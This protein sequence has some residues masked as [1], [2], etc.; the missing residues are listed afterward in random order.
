[1]VNTERY[2]NRL[3][4]L[5]WDDRLAE[6]ARDYSERKYRT[7]RARSLHKRSSE[8]L[9]AKYHVFDACFVVGNERN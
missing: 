9:R 3:H 2:K 8:N 6:M 5:G 4:N 7:S 1:M